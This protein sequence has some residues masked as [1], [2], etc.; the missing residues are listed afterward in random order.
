MNTQQWG[1]APPVSPAEA[2]TK[3]LRLQNPPSKALLCTSPRRL[4]DRGPTPTASRQLSL[5]EASFWRLPV[6]SGF[7]DLP[8]GGIPV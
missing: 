3:L 7:K 2:V 6:F 5:A 8:Q 4:A 1:T